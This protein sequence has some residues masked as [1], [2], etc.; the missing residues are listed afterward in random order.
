MAPQADY[1]FLLQLR[2]DVLCDVQTR[3]LN[4][5]LL[6]NLTLTSPISRV[7]AETVTPFQMKAHWAKPELKIAKDVVT[8][9]VDVAGGARYFV[10][11]INLTMK[12]Q[13]S[14]GCL[15][16]AAANDSGQ[17]VVTLAAP[18][19]LD[20]RLGELELS[21]AGDDDLLTEV[22]KSIERMLLRPTLCTQLMA[23]LASLPL[24]FL[25]D[26][27]PLRLTAGPGH[28]VAS[29]EG[30]T[31][32]DAAVSLDPPAD[33]L[34]LTMRRALCTA[35]PA[36]P[37]NLLSDHTAANAVVAVSETGLNS[38]LGWLCE[39]GL[40]TGTT[41][42]PGGPVSWHW[43]H[44]TARFTDHAIHLTGRLWQ[45]QSPM[46]VDAELRC[47]LTS[48]AQLSV[49]LTAPDRQMPD[50]DVLL[51][52]WAQLLRRIFF[53]ATH[54]P[55]SRRGPAT[56]PGTDQ[57][58]RQRFVI[59][60]TDLFA[61]APAV[62]LEL[63]EGYLVA[64]YAIPP[65][66]QP[67]SLTIEERK[68]EPTLSQPDI[69]FQDAPGT[70]VTTQLAAALADAPEPP[71]DYAWRVD[72]EPRSRQ[73]HSPTL[74]V[75]R[76]PPPTMATGEPQKLATVTLKVIDILGQVGEA[77]IDA[78]YSSA[79]AAQHQEQRPNGQEG[80]PV[81]LA[82]A[83]L[84]AS[85]ARLYQKWKDRW[86]KMPA[87]LRVTGPAVAA[88]IVIAI[89]AFLAFPGGATTGPEPTRNP[90]AL[91]TSQTT[92]TTP[93]FSS[94]IQP[95]PPTTHATSATPSRPPQQTSSS[96]QQL[97]FIPAPTHTNTPPSLRPTTALSPTTTSPPP[98]PNVS[99]IT[100]VGSCAPADTC[101]SA[102]LCSGCSTTFTGDCSSGV[103]VDYRSTIYVDRG[104]A[105]IFFRWVVN[106]TAFPVETVD[107]TGADSQQQIVGVV[108]I[109]YNST[110]LMTAQ[111]EILS[112]QQMESNIVTAQITCE[113]D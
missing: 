34:T 80:I 72:Q 65:D 59:P 49:R 29:A 66:E 89:L 52:A 32:A 41:D 10:E 84:S 106:D 47:S 85:A 111:L 36:P 21:Y 107:F 28:G 48:A 75:T 87:V 93:S 57:P 94:Y 113:S 64:L 74:T 79:A 9:S 109:L 50:A 54:S 4:A 56:E 16:Q 100:S 19:P 23:P 37:P 98:P 76:T 6:T 88:T 30:L 38:I 103:T 20:L 101:D 73:H 42:H 53:A 77:E 63:R 81:A 7:L 71:Y 78:M 62:N 12:N 18:A 95:L 5:W 61:E 69:P 26:A 97:P 22:D 86:I 112:P 70:P 24:N 44:V 31:L 51:E 110:G 14:A 55:E 11:G 43:T 17:P 40:A 92:V 67:F 90:T 104:P 39:Q 105:Q 2:S 3:I 27:V 13:V 102:P 83:G 15:P 46:M 58:L 45:G 96:T 60:G 108:T 68:P 8:L 33:S 25:P 82:G 35:T 91:P 1:D 99:T